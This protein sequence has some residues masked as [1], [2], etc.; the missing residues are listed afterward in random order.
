MIQRIQ[1]LWFL[2]ATIAAAL[3]FFYPVLGMTAEDTL[4]IYDYQ[5]ISIGSLDNIL[6]SGYVLAG[7]AGIISL[8]S[9]VNIFFFKRRSLQMRICVFISI[10]VIIF[11]A[12]IL[13]FS[14][15]ND[16]DFVGLGL[17]SILP[18]IVFI[19][20]LMGR[21][22]VLRDEILLRSANRLR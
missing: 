21:R 12:L 15:M 3:I 18:F 1:S 8:L 20:T 7:L 2:G 17:S 10:L 4:Y 19:F 9:F 6:P 11:I 5:S 22:A 14:L 16:N 13:T